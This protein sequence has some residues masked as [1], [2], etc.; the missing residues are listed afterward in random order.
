[1]KPELTELN[2]EIVE[3]LAAAGATHFSIARNYDKPNDKKTS[4]I[5][6]FDSDKVDNNGSLNEVAYFMPDMHSPKLGKSSGFQLINRSN[7]IDVENVELIPREI[8]G[9]YFEFMHT[10][11]GMCRSYYK[12]K[13]TTD[14]YC[15]QE[16]TSA[17]YNLY[18]CTQDGEPSF[19]VSPNPKITSF[20][21]PTCD[22]ITGKQIVDFL[23][24]SDFITPKVKKG[25]KIS[26]K[27]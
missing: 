26:R 22:T 11:N 14:L 23:A 18:V 24:K 5:H 15:L 13:N 21:N 8:R 20:E 12:E 17:S 7:G 27:M 9:R 19:S 2:D 3:S 1:M 4:S 16:E 25:R 6:F 10:D